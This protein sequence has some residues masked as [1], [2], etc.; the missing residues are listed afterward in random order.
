MTALLSAARSIHLL[1]L[2]TIFGGSAYVALLR[3]AKLV[4][5][6]VRSM[7]ILFVTAATLA[8][9]SGLVW[10]GLI[11][12]QMSGS[13]QGSVDPAVLR[14]AALDTR[15]GHIF[16][17]RI[18]GLIVVGSLCLVI[19]RPAGLTMAILAGLL[20]V[21]LAPVSHAAASGGDIAIAG[22]ASDATHLLAAGFWL[23]GLFA[24]DLVIGRHRD[25]PR[26]L[27][28]PLRIFSTW[29]T[30]VVI[31]LLL[32]GVANALSILPISAMTLRNPYFEL[33]LVKVA[34]GALMA[35]LASLNRWRFAPALP[36]DGETAVGNLATSVGLEIA[37]GLLVVAIVGYLGTMAPH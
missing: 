2:M 17:P 35:G 19:A 34:L 1:S 27:V 28:G 13:W 10:F 37:F 14:L 36:S 4:E 26:A 20:L 5:P 33:L 16:V 3:R 23:G 15:F 29:G 21:S 12:G 18:I 30:P 7:R 31:F 25:E 32:S 24:L 9:L 6:S 11:A 22:A 8:V